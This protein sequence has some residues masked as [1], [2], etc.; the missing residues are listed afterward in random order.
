MLLIYKNL[1][2]F[3]QDLNIESIWRSTKMI[4]VVVNSDSSTYVSK[5][6]SNLK[7]GV[8]VG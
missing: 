8:A 2:F 1:F 3:R 4:I 6:F 7:I 5:T